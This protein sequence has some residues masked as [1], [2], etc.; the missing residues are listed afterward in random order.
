MSL[1]LRLLN[2]FTYVG[3]GRPIGFCHFICGAAHFDILYGCI[4]LTVLIDFVKVEVGQG[5]AGLFN[6]S[7]ADLN[8]SS[9]HQQVLV[10]AY[11]DS[12]QSHE[13]GT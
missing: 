9:V 13:A 8:E 11:S 2:F 6:R 1:R 4:V 3:L 7:S 10:W 12:R 5:A